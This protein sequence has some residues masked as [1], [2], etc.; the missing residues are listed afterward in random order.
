MTVGG[1]LINYPGDK[2][3]C[4]AELETTKI[5]FNSVVSTPEA[6]FCT[7][8][9]TTFY[10]NTPLD[11]PEYLCIPV[12]LI[13]EE[14]MRVYQLQSLVKNGNV[15]ARIDKGMYSLPQ[16]GILAN[17]LLKERLQPHG[18]HECKHTPGLWRHKKRAL[19]FSLVVDR[20]A[21]PTGSAKQ[22]YKAITVDWTGSLFC[23][24][25][26]KWDDTQRI[27]NLSMLGTCKLHSKNSNTIPEW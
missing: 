3:T 2:S 18:Y 24:I 26:L 17:R 5:L 12:T 23:S 10:L 20:R 9:I 16:A 8:D 4:T 25:T 22:H 11:C 19:M 15:M 13:P 6:R 14:I 27:V 21:T 7:M 1:N